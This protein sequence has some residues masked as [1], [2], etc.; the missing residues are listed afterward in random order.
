MALPPPQK[1]TMTFRC[2][3]CGIEQGQGFRTRCESCDGLMEP[4]Y[5][6][7]EFALRDGDSPMERYFDLIPLESPDSIVSFESANTPCVHAETLGRRIGLDALFL[8]DETVHPTGTTK[9]RMASCVLSFFSE[10]G[11]TEFVANASTGNSS[12]SLIHGLQYVDNIKLHL[13]CGTA[14]VERTAG[15]DD[16]RVE[17]HVV[18]GKYDAATAAA[19]DF[20]ASSGILFEAGFFNPSRRDGLKLAYLEAFDQMP[21]EPNVVIQACS[22]GMGM[23]GAYNGA[24]QY[25]ELGRLSALPRF[26]CAQENT[27]AP[28]HAAF[29]DGSAVIEDRHIFRDADGIAKAIMRGNPIQ[30]YPYLYDIVTRTGG[31]FPTVSADE[32][33]RARQELAEDEGIET[34]FAAAVTVAAVRKLVESGYIR[35]DE[36]VLLN[37]TGNNRAQAETARRAS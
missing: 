4:L 9:D 28:M 21:A 1:K 23:V 36:V 3:R 8:K 12:T 7:S 37:L 13:F 26:V 11:V 31:S 14:F 32:I 6:L 35:R 17:L 2:V 22:S 29:T 25:R 24:L 15:L 33:R 34:E 19:R 5:D 10:L 16:H 20:A 30:S 27:C 18:D